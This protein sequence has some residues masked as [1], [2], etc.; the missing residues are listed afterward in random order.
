MTTPTPALFQNYLATAN[1]VKGPDIPSRPAQADFVETCLQEGIADAAAHIYDKY[2]FASEAPMTFERRCSSWLGIALSQAMDKRHDDLYKARDIISRTR[3]A[4][5]GVREKR[6]QAEADLK[7]VERQ[8]DQA[9]MPLEDRQSPLYEPLTDALSEPDSVDGGALGKKKKNTVKISSIS[10]QMIGAAWNLIG[11]AWNWC[12]R[13]SWPKLVLGAILVAGEIGLIYA[14]ALQLGDAEIT[15]I[16]IALSVSGLAIGAGW[17]A[18][19][20]LLQGAEAQLSR[21]VLSSITLA[22]YVLTIVSLGWIRYLYLRPEAVGLFEDSLILIAAEIILPWYGD[23]LFYLLW[24]ALPLALTATVGLLHT[25]G[26][27]GRGSSEKQSVVDV[28]LPGSAVSGTMALPPVDVPVPGKA[29]VVDRKSR[30]VQS[31]LIGH[32]KDLRIR[33]SQLQ[34]RIITLKAEEAHGQTAQEDTKLNETAI[35]ERTRLYIQSLPEMIS[36]G[37]IS[38]LKGLERGFADPTMTAHIEEAQDAFLRRFKDAAYLKVKEH[39]ASLDAHPLLVPAEATSSVK[40][41]QDET[42]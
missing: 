38:Y 10:S 37:F 14:I 26:S 17:L 7:E 18:I 30:R 29:A 23:L 11:G 33:R 16:L 31:Y 24:V 6:L 20:T 4:A 39:L 36:E 22:L 8:I 42:V 41:L 27:H 1:A 3:A 35:N 34:E 40:E 13:Q 25:H 19:P 32:L 15:A 5:V 9:R 28:S 2:S 12:Q 21:K